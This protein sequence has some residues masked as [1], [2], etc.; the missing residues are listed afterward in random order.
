MWFNS[1]VSSV[2]TSEWWQEDTKYYMGL[3]RSFVTKRKKRKSTVTDKYTYNTY[4][5]KGGQG[6]PWV[7]RKQGM[8]RDDVRWA[9]QRSLKEAKSDR[10]WQWEV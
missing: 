4:K 7:P 8:R 2:T 9:E 1:A 3:S 10:V 5:L 6:N